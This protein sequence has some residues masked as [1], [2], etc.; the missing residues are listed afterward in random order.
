MTDAGVTEY[1]FQ[2][3]D[4]AANLSSIEDGAK[5]TLEAQGLSGIIRATVDISID[6]THP[7]AELTSLDATGITQI[8]DFEINVTFSEEVGNVDIGDFRLVLKGADTSVDPTL[9]TIVVEKHS[10]STFSDTSPSTTTDATRLSGTYFKVIVTPQ[11]DLMT[12]IDVTEYAFQVIDDTANSSSIVDADGNTLVTQGL[13]GIIR[14]TADINIDTAA[15]KTQF[16]YP[17]TDGEITVITSTFAMHIL[18]TETVENVGIDN[19][20]FTNDTDSSG[21][22]ESVTVYDAS[23]TTPG[24]STDTSISLSGRYFRISINVSD[25]IG[26]TY[27]FK[28][29]PTSITDQ[30]GNTFQTSTKDQADLIVDTRTT[31]T[32]YMY[33]VDALTIP[34]NT[35]DFEIN[36]SFGEEVSNVDIGDFRLVSRFADAV[37]DDTFGTI[38]VEKHSD[39]TFTDENPIT[40]DTTTT[41]LS[42]RYFKVIVSPQDD[43]MTDAG[44]TE[45]SFQVIDDTANSSSIVD[46]D[47]NTLRKHNSYEI[48]R[49]VVY[50]NIDTLHPKTESTSL[51]TPGTQTSTFDV[52]VTFSE[53]VNNVDISDFEFIKTDNTDPLN[54][55]T[56]SVGTVTKVEVH[57]YSSFNDTDP[58]TTT[59]TTDTLSG[60]YFKVSINP[61]EDINDT[62]TFKVLPTSITDQSGNSFQTSTNDTFDVVVNINRI[63]TLTS[64]SITNP[65]VTPKTEEFKI[66]IVFSEVVY[67]VNIE[68]FQF[69]D[70]TTSVG[71]ITKV[72]VFDSA[73]N[74]SSIS[75]TD[76]TEVSGQYFSVS[77]DPN[78]DLNSNGTPAVTY[79]FEVLSSE[80]IIDEASNS[81]DG[82]DGEATTL[83]VEV[84]TLTPLIL[85]AEIVNKTLVLTSSISLE[86]ASVIGAGGFAVTGSDSTVYTVYSVAVSGTTITLTF[87]AGTAPKKRGTY[88]YTKN[89]TLTIQ[90]SAS[91]ALAKIE[92]AVYGTPLSLNFDEVAGFSAN[93]ALFLYLKTQKAYTPGPNT[94]TG[95]LDSPSLLG[96]A[97]GNVADAIA[98]PQGS[99]LDLDGVGGY[100]SNEGLFLYLKTQKAYTPGTNT[101]TG[102]LD[103]PSLLGVA[104]SRVVV[105]VNAA[106]K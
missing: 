101:L 56:S 32:A 17:D 1:V 25:E 104:E 27:T 60:R 86:T 98:G 93:E 106:K 79:T 50:I 53:S 90:T 73:F 102:L 74:S 2:V 69:T 96:V 55:I 51:V 80:G 35:G 100:T 3:I 22:I 30:H 66:N 49:G 5:N 46:A 94:F 11:D 6:T 34:I 14:A 62:Y 84:D 97:E 28:V 4:D 89:S 44:V 63:P 87:A 65:S 58:S 39:Y 8:G 43:L 37:D 64:V 33:L 29:L 13:S 40:T 7:K 82:M 16:I 54:P 48:R 61:N 77:I 52:N 76:T 95:L 72:E 21:V 47:G 57:S 83:D 24:D 67:S 99:F 38:V 88:S 81:F 41:Q 31:P 92:G 85:D 15:P 20:E 42:G 91:N 26:D 18:F 103:S 59:T 10:D 19:F 12:D 70:G 75:T 9:G 105:L 23:F 78:D 71:E 36:V 45:Y 68:D